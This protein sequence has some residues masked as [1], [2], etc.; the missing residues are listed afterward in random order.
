MDGCSHSAA[1]EMAG[2]AAAQDPDVDAAPLA[3][4]L[5]HLLEAGPYSEPHQSGPP[6]HLVPH[7]LSHCWALYAGQAQGRPW[8]NQHAGYLHNNFNQAPGGPPVAAVHPLP[9]LAGHLNQAERKCSAQAR[10]RHHTPPDDGTTDR[11]Q[12][13]NRLRWTAV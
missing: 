5:G 11:G 4:G 3:L 2:G 12:A 8:A 7:C 1:L 13:E 9:V 10:L 6:P